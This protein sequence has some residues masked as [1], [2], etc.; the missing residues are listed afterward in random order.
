MHS[1]L[2]RKINCPQL[3]SR[4]F[5]QICLYSPGKRNGCKAKRRAETCRDSVYSLLQ[6]GSAA[7]KKARYWWFFIYRKAGE[8]DYPNFFMSIAAFVRTVKFVLLLAN[9]VETMCVF[10]SFNM[11][12]CSLFIIITIYVWFDVVLLQQ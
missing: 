1:F 10:C 3:H 11:P 2:W 12:D 7:T 9:S 6:I 4:H 5:K 8:D